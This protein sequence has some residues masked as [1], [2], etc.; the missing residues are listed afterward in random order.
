MKYLIIIILSIFISCSAFYRTYNLHPL[1][2]INKENI[3]GEYLFN[4][5]K[6]KVNVLTLNDTNAY[7]H[8][9]TSTIFK[10][11]E[12]FINDTLSPRYS[13]Y[14][15][16]FGEPQEC[17]D[18]PL[19]DYWPCIDSTKFISMFVGNNSSI[20]VNKNG[21]LMCSMY[22]PNFNYRIEIQVYKKQ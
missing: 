16:K 20:Y 6:G 8:F 5:I 12:L 7:L 18:V 15:T 21:K 11:A 1:P 3:S 4:G 13:Y 22:I 10:D 2:P 9:N 17:P 19:C 14:C